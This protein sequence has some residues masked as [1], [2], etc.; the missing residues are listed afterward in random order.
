MAEQTFTAGQILTAAQMTT[1]QTN[2][3]LNYITSATIGTGVS[4]V[5]V[6]GCFTSTYTDYVIKITK[7]VSSTSQVIQLA[8]NA[9]TGASYYSFGYYQAFNSATLTGENFAVAT[10]KGVVGYVDGVVNMM[11]IMVGGPQVNNWTTAQSD[12]VAGGGSS[13]GGT[14]RIIDAAAFQNT[15]FTLSVAGTLTGGTVTVYGVRNA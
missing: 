2:I 7:T 11:S 9:S 10:G 12:Y 3:G 14:V 4:S 6:A 13:R 1:L 5:S 8:F 15:G